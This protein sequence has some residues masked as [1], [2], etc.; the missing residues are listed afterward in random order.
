MKRIAAF[1]VEHAR[2]AWFLA[3]LAILGAGLLAGQLAGQVKESERLSLLTTEAERR[4]IE[5]MSQTLNG[6][7]M[8]SARTSSA[9]R[10]ASS[11]PMAR[12]WRR[13]SKASAAPSTPMACS[14]L[15]P[16]ASPSPP[17]TTAASP[18]PD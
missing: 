8:G 5:I 14:S 16:T 17:G 2:L 12:K 6:N 15:A 7:L 13:R 9:K 11:S 4:G 18:R 1:V 10:A 3:L